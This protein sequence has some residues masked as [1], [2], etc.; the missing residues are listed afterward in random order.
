MSGQAAWHRFVTARSAELHDGYPCAMPTGRVICPKHGARVG[1]VTR[2]CKPCRDELYAQ[3]VAEFTTTPPRRRPDERR[4]PLH[5]FDNLL[6]QENDTEEI[7][8]EMLQVAE[9]MLILAE[10]AV[11]GRQ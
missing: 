11:G 1:P 4:N 10:E 3:L 2:I 6:D 7:P 8:D 5:D 9:A